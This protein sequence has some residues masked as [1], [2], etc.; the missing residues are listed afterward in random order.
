MKNMAKRGSCS[1]IPI[2]KFLLFNKVV[3]HFSCGHNCLHKS[4]FV[5]FFNLLFTV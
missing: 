3:K 5:I 1:Y 4:I 2:K